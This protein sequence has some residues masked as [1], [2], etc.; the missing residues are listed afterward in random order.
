M[1]IYRAE[2]LLE[3]FVHLNILL[4][5]VARAVSQNTSDH[6]SFT[7]CGRLRERLREWL[8]VGSLASKIFPHALKRLDFLVTF[9]ITV[10]IVQQ[11]NFVEE[12][13]PEALG[14]HD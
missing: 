8:A 14:A 3:F 9:N 6:Y 13:V 11:R 12:L 2:L 4:P 7:P 1:W 10:E 5:R